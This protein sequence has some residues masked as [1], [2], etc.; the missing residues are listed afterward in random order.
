M[1]A[2]TVPIPE[3]QPLRP[4]NCAGALFLVFSTIAVLLV[5]RSSLQC[6][7]VRVLNGIGPFAVLF[8]ARTLRFPWLCAW[9][10]FE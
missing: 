2:V 5:K 8:T 10:G 9:N 6:R 4:L 1:D 3:M 7:A